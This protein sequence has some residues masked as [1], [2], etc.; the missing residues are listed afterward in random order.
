MVHS[1]Q[2]PRMTAV[3]YVRA[4]QVLVMYGHYVTPASEVHVARRP[5]QWQLT[6]WP[7][8]HMDCV[9]VSAELI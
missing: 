1:M 5:S 7:L 9:R 4:T 3:I 8:A 6:V 2:S